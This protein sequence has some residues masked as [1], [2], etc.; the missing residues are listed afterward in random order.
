MRAKLLLLL[1]FCLAIKLPFAATPSGA[2]N[3]APK[4]VSNFVRAAPL[5]KW[6]QPLAE[7]PQSKHDDTVVVR[8][9]ESQAWVGP[10]PAVLQNMAIQVNGKSAL[11]SIGQFGISYV[12]AYQK[13]FLHRVALL[14]GKEI[15]DRTAS[16]NTRLLERET[17]IEHGVYGGAT[18]VQLLL[19]DVHVGDTLWLTYTVE[20]VNPVFGNMWSDAFEWDS[21][22]PVESRKLTILHPK[23]RPLQW[24]TLGDFKSTEVKPVIDQLGTNERLVFSEQG[25]EALDYEASTPSDYISHRRLLFT[26][27]SNWHEVAVWAS[28]LFPRL[29]PSPVTTALVRK[30]ALQ[31]DQMA[32][33]SAAL[34]WV[35]DE[36][37]YFSVSMGENSHRPQLPEIVL[38]HRYGD[39]KDKSYLLVTL[40]R[41]LGI[42]ATPC[43]GQCAG[44]TVTR[45]ITADTCPI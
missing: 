6:A 22:S 26:E 15:I 27:F 20:G 5:P 40:L 2:N 37:R 28:G 45:E 21:A 42:K 18:T 4:K 32:Q 33:A 11:D 29:P 25:I 23:N 14:R 43:T 31:G 36:I 16:V 41:D 12:P 35:Q 24:R 8:L 38:K 13:L 17:G 1:I 44:T 19:E 3:M 39:C 34:H 30:F 7:I 10:T 9:S